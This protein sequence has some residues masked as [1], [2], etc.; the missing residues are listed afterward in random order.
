MKRFFA[1]LRGRWQALADPF[2]TA[3]VM[4]VPRVPAR[5]D[6]VAVPLQPVV[7]AL[8]Q[9]TLTISRQQDELAELGKAAE[10]DT[11]LIE[12][13]RREAQELRAELR[14]QTTRAD[15]AEEC[16]RDLQSEQA[17]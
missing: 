13:F 16:L 2:A 10:R 5:S 8:R 17:S 1:W 11:E 15:A 14:E 3:P 9:A 7:D 4:E 6:L 12:Q